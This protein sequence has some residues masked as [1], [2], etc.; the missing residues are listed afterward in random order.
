MKDEYWFTKSSSKI[1]KQHFGLEPDDELVK[2]M[3]SLVEAHAVEA[4]YYIDGFT[5]QEIKFIFNNFPFNRF[6]KS[7]L[8]EFFKLI[9]AGQNKKQIALAWLETNDLAA[10]IEKFKVKEFDPTLLEFLEGKIDQKSVNWGVGQ[11]MKKYPNIYS[12]GEVKA[13]IEK[14]WRLNDA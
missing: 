1:L 14:K 10:A 7:Q 11:V 13:A 12:A 5:A 2:I 9:Q 4:W 6:Q 3:D 8:L